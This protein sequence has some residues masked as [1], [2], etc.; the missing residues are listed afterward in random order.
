MCRLQWTLPRQKVGQGLVASG[1]I[2]V[3]QRL[4]NS[5]PAPRA[6]PA[7]KLRPFLTVDGKPT[8]LDVAKATVDQARSFAHVP[9]CQKTLWGSTAS[10]F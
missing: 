8:E 6:P 1:E 3:P 2:G 9:H 7:D 5:S 10:R 4:T